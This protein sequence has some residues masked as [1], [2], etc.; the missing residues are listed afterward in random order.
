MKKLLMMLVL[1]LNACF[2]YAQ[3]D[4][5]VVN[6]TV[7][8]K[9]GI[10]IPGVTV[11]E[12]GTTNGTITDPDGVYR[13]KLTSEKAT[14]VYSFIGFTTQEIAFSGKNRINVVLEEEMKD[15]NEVVVIGYGEVRKRDVTGSVSSI[16]EKDEVARQY[17]SVDLLLQGRA[18]GIQVTGNSGNPGGAVSV[19]IRGTNSLRGNNEPLYVVDGVIISSAGMDVSDPSSDA[20][21]LQSQ[22]NG[23]SGL[24]PQDIERVEVLKDASATAIY[25]SRGA[26]GVVLITTKSGSESDKG[27]ATINLFGS[28]EFN[29][30]N[31]KIDL[32]DGV[33]F[34]KYQNEINANVGLTPRYII[35]GQKVYGYAVDGEGNPTI[36]GNPLR[37]VDWQDEIYSVNLSH[38]E[39]V[40]ISGGNAKNK[41]YFSG[42]FTNSKGVV[43]TTD[44]KRGDLRLNLNTELN[45]RLKLDTRIS[46]MYSRGSFAQ[47]GS[48]SGGNR[49]FTKQ[50]LSYSPIP[51]NSDVVDEQD[52]EVSNPYAWLTDFEDMTREV[53][54]NLS[55]AAT[56]DLGKGFKFKSSVGI[57]FWKKDRSKWYDVGVFVG[58]K[59]NGLA[60]YSYLDRYAYV[61]DN[62]LTFDKRINEIHQLNVVAGTTYDGVYSNSRVYEIAN[63]PDKSLGSDYPTNGQTV[64][65]PFTIRLAEE[66]VWSLLG[67][68]N[69]S[70]KDK[71]VFTGSFRADKST[72]F[73]GDNK[74]GVYPSLALAWRVMEEPFVKDLNLFHNLKMRMGW[75]Q[76]GNQAISPYNTLMLYNSTQYA[77]ADNSNMVGN[78]PANIANPNLTWEFSEQYNA[79]LDMGFLQGKLN[80]TVDLYHKK[81][82][83]LLLEKQLPGSTGFDKMFVN[84]GS[85]QNK[86]LE[87]TLDALAYERKDWSVN[88][89]ANFA[90]NRNEVLSLGNDIIPI[91]VYIDSKETQA[92]LY[93]GNSVSTGTY[94]K[95]PANVFMVG[96]AMG[97]FWGYKTDGIYQ[98]PDQATAGPKL[99][100]TPAMAGDV[101]FVDQNKD[102]N[103]DDADK[104]I[105]GNPNPDFTYGLNLSVRFKR[106]SLS[107]LFNGVQGNDVVNGYNMELG[108]AEGRGTNILK[109]A[110]YQAWR[111]DATDVNNPAVLYNYP[112]IGFRGNTFLSDRIVEDGSYF[113]LN[114]LTL[115]YDF[116][117]SKLKMFSRINLYASGRNLFI[118]TN[119]TGFN[120]QITSF[121]NDGS[122]MGVDWVGTPNV[123]TYLVGVNLSF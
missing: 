24:N 31:K 107:A 40:N 67:R 44:I 3:Q 109:D 52:L 47:G 62:I 79:G 15:L 68:V 21:E 120:P 82:H 83:D 32:L 78:V 100:G 117:V 14:M 29:V 64:K 104:T 36:A 99:N 56:Y 103:I 22:Q 72:K 89:G 102:G 10:P 85:I 118:L 113:M 94:F 65:T 16:K 8:D 69:Y 59:E 26:N 71:Y 76:T 122:I 51:S 17:P 81:T 19:R 75:G 105:I 43:E 35:D 45:K 106:L 1:L 116:N 87:V 55:E 20:N 46:L 25:G 50:V 58:Q 48:K 95:Q 114:N 28:T 41:Y 2:I 9:M 77:S 4:K 86:G 54:I 12:K 61:F 110:Y 80:A 53:R 96:K 111:P 112:R 33:G 98:T 5:I 84:Q 18:P 70:L 108:Y 101:A 37:L 49:S 39:G 121:L 63:F 60:N 6:G 88:V 92:E 38:N 13:L 73:L 115:S 123:R 90:I 27:K 34:A 30:V 119:Y 74:W 91:T 97:L 7:T 23:L 57:D 11:L 66:A 42:S 93:Y